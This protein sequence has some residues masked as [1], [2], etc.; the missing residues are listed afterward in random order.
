MKNLNRY[1]K[2]GHHAFVWLYALLGRKRLLEMREALQVLRVESLPWD[3][4]IELARQARPLFLSQKLT[5]MRKL[6]KV[7]EYVDKQGFKGLA[8]HIVGRLRDSA[9]V[10]YVSDQLLH[11]QDHFYRFAEAHE[12]FANAGFEF[13]RVLQGMSNTLQESFGDEPIFKNRG[14]F[15]QMETYRL[16]ELYEQPEGFGFLIRK[17]KELN[18]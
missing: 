3:E 2:P 7:L 17:T 13:V 6:I 8:R 11:P 9:S 4:R 18:E 5:L 15:S 10:T 16:I 14:G 12:L 1:L